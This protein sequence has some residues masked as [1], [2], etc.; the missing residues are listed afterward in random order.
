[1][2]DYV[3]IF[4]L[5]GVMLFEKNFLGSSQKSQI[6][7]LVNKFIEKVFIEQK[8]GTL[9]QIRIDKKVFYF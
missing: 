7:S 6:K 3:A 4:D 9:T 8:E 2:L 5:G 1:M